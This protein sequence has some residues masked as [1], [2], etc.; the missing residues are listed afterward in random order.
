M[1]TVSK[2]ENVRPEE[3]E[4]A[5][6]CRQQIN[7][8]FS[9][10]FNAKEF[11]TPGQINTFV[12][13]HAC[14]DMRGQDSSVPCSSSRQPKSYVQGKINCVLA[15]MEALV[16]SYWKKDFRKVDIYGGELQDIVIHGLNEYEIMGTQRAG[17]Y[18]FRRG[19]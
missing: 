1:G 2:L 18:L 5:K 8:L 9:Q 6:K 15:L 3:V 19:A 14:L 7:A 17:Y 4:R 16:R 12:L 13:F 10:F 11:F